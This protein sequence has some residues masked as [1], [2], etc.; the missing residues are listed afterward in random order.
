ML[1]FVEE[2]NGISAELDKRVKFEIVVIPPPNTE[3]AAQFNRVKIAIIL[4]LNRVND[5][6]CF[7]QV[8]IMM[9]DLAND[10]DYLWPKEKFLV[11]FDSIRDIYRRSQNNPR[12][13]SRISLVSYEYFLNQRPCNCPGFP[14]SGGRSFPRGRGRSGDN[15]ISHSRSATTSLF[16]ISVKS[17]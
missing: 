8:F 16:G 15:R 17:L 13:D 7:K 14:V 10:C 4:L 9:K 6:S 3:N 5:V 2:A 1:P 11:R 12:E